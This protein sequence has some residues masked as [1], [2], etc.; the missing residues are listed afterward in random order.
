MPSTIQ[1]NNKRIAKNTLLLYLRMLF[2]MAVN[3]YVSRVV[4]NI[5]GV[6]NYGIYSV[7]G[8]I[9]VIFTFINSSM[10]GAT[11]RFLNFEMGQGDTEAIVRVFNTAQVIHIGIS[12]VVL[13]M[14]ETIGLWFLNS[15]MNIPDGRMWTAN[16]VFQFSAI[17]FV[18]N[19]ISVPYNATIIAHEKMSAF[20]YISIYEALAKLAVS[21]S[22]LL[23]PFDKLIAYGALIMVVQVSV[24]I[25][26]GVY[27]S[28]HFIEC[29]HF[30]L[31]LD[32]SLTKS[33]LSFSS[34]T[35]VGSLSSVAHT[36]G[37]AIIINIF[38]GAAVNAAQGIANQVNGIIN[39]F[40]SNFLIAMNPQVVKNYATG[41]L[42]QMHKL[43]FRGSRFAFYL[44][45]FFV[46]PLVL[47]APTI[48]KTWLKVVPDYTVM[49]VRLVLL[50]S[51]LNS[52]AYL[53]STSQGA[54]GDI[55]KYQITLT[56]ISLF[57][58]P[59]TALFY[60]LGGNP[61]WAMYVYLVIIV[62]MQI[63]RIYFVSYAVGFKQS[64]FYREVVLKCCLVF[65]ASGV[66]PFLLHLL[67]HPCF[68]TSLIVCITCIATVGLAS[69][70]LGMTLGEREKIKS[71]LISRL[72]TLEHRN[73]DS[74]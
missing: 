3:L 19:V 53:L 62:V 20:A 57:H 45:S 38:F 61:Y 51:L 24:R 68:I 16:W 25:I 6:E 18:V 33:M 56:I 73:R 10:A 74:I 5:L 37:V 66:I 17:T 9:V 48:L 46:I 63:Y 69:L 55:K 31:H 35:V 49:F 14:A 4:L 29:N 43:I 72:H 60:W 30:S 27:C 59:L 58:L 64:T 12:C 70:Y 32:K 40:V 71:S 7:V 28:K 39:Q 36:Q 47:E 11:Q 34:W 41:D 22:L 15:C 1:E 23:V 42:D 44:I 21:F 13:L 2:L 65:V 8:G 52:C 54:T 67:M 50:I 26:Y